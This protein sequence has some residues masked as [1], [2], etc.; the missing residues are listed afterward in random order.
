M[1]YDGLDLQEG[2]LTAISDDGEDMLEI[3][4]QDGM[5]LDVG[6]IECDGKYYVTVAENESE[7]AWN[8]PLDVAETAD[9]NMLME[10]IQQEIF[11]FRR[12]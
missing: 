9:K 12:K 6:Y 8:S 5:F 3:R 2:I 7:E 1:E 11:K 4:W 10:L